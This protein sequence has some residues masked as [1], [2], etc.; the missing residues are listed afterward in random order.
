[1]ADADFTWMHSGQLGAPQMNGASGSNGQLLQLLDACLINGFNAQTVVSA[2]KTATTVTFTYGTN[3]GYVDRQLVDVSGATEV[4][5]NGKH[6]VVALTENTITVNAIGVSSLSGTISTKV[7]P[8]GFASIF[9]STDPLKRAYRSANPESTQT[10]LY[11]DMAI[12]AGGGYDASSPAKVARV[13]FCEDMTEL[14]VQIGSYSD[15]L[16]NYASNVN[17]SLF[18]YQAKGAIE[19]DS[20]TTN[21]NGSWVVFGNGDYFYFMPEWTTFSTYRGQKSRDFYAFGDVP[22]LSGEQD[23][24]NCLWIG[25]VNINNRERINYVT[26]NGAKV[27]GNPTSAGDRVGYF[28]AKSSGLGGAQPL[29]ISSSCN[30]SQPLYFSG[31]SGLPFPNASTQSLI[32]VPLYGLSAGDLRT[33]MTR[34]LAIPQNM[35]NTPLASYDL[36]IFGD[37]LVVALAHYIGATATK[38][39]SYLAFDVSY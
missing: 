8:L 38:Y 31:A 39:Y 34:L 7:A 13:S 36:N 29:V 11:L 35:G 2:T 6:R 1:M 12:P 24:F 5:L 10:V 26:S 20:V 16:N 9:G 37:L 14:G 28:I 32:G 3:H 22:S 17:G 15:A 33:H 30:P 18:W 19:S 23:N 27:D 4:N 21:Q 25:S